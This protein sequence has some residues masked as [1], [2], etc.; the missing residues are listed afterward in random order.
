[1]ANES[2]A[3]INAIKITVSANTTTAKNN[4]DKLAESLKNLKSSVG[5][6]LNLPNAET[7]NAFVTA[8]HGLKGVPWTRIAN[9]LQKITDA[10][11]GVKGGNAAQMASAMQKMATT[12]AISGAIDAGTTTLPKATGVTA[13][14]L[15]DANK[16][17]I[18]LAASLGK[19]GGFTGVMK[20]VGKGFLDV[21]KAGLTAAQYVGKFSV[22]VVKTTA[23]VAVAPF[24]KLASSI[25]SV[26]KRFT[27]FFAAI[28]RIAVYRAIRTALKEIA[29]GFKEG[30]D[31]LYQYSKA[32]DGTFA[33]SM[34]TLATS[35]LYAK[36]SLGAMVAPIVNELAPAVDYLVDQFVDL[37]N[38][39]NETIAAMTGA[40]TWTKALKYPVEYAEEA[41]NATKSAKKLRATLLGFDEIN[42]LDDNSKSNRGSG[43]EGLDYSRMFE[44]QVVS[45]QA[46]G[47][48]GA[49]KD[50][51]ASG[52]F[53]DIGATLGEKIK[54]GLDNIPWGQIKE[55]LNKNA[56]SVGSFL[57]GLISVE[58]AGTSLGS[59]IAE[60]FDTAVGKLGTFFNTVHWNK[61]GDF[62]GDGINGITSSS[63]SK[64]VGG[65]IASIINGGVSTLNNFADKVDWDK[66][67]R[68][69]ANGVN[70]AI[71]TTDTRA[72]GESVSKMVSGALKSAAAFLRDTDF[73]GLGKKIGQFFRGI[74]WKEVFLSAVDTIVNGMKAMVRF[75]IGLVPE[76]FGGLKDAVTGLFKSLGK[77]IKSLFSW[78]GGFFKGKG[79]SAGSNLKSGFG[80]SGVISYLSGKV[81]SIKDLFK[82]VAPSIK[83]K[84]SDAVDGIKEVFK[85]PKKYFSEKV[86][87]I[88][89]A[90]LNIPNW[91]SEKFSEAWEAIKLVFSDPATFFEGVWESIKKK[92]TDI[93]QK[94]GNAMGAAFG[95]A[96]NVALAAAE[97]VINT[98]IKAINKLLDIINTLPKVNIGKLDTISLPR[99]DLSEY[100][101][102][103]TPATGS[104]FLAGERGAE[105]IS[106]NRSGT[107]VTNR[108]QLAESVEAGN[109]ESNDLLRQGVALLQQ[110]VAKDTTVVN[111][112][113]TNSITTAMNR[114]NVRTGRS[115]VAVG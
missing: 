37:L 1:M 114:Q 76:I 15:T 83:K 23:K 35:A 96:I 74:N 108:D 61:V 92:F 48:I 45:K 62:L 53:E 51:F 31:N 100:A 55:R 104:L 13:G 3:T 87:S 28:K 80:N 85:D 64:D 32:I 11:S 77:N 107:T 102:G 49:L 47:I 4:L 70:K 95:S 52:D 66:A 115:V 16:G 106:S 34:D 8:M 42:R 105:L 33:K 94:V 72:L 93:G 71:K 109:A 50:A 43:E 97:S 58:G 46:G 39:I 29:Q 99:L 41:D 90:F 18:S 78:V 98:P 68:F 113:T 111:E 5:E 84:F 69:T 56:Q 75:L 21:G 73:E 20:D 88:K 24:K 81:S 27:S 67:G 86:E 12:T 38:T 60:V 25:T 65:T 17:A 22:A 112:I 54:T 82:D 44:E 19:I 91:F 89:E 2:S 7:I 26:T 103:G 10:M 6:G 9:G 57:N 63:L 36:N 79:K 14:E 30:M 110:L 59:T 101:K 40:S